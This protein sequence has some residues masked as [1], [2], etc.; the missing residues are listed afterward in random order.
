MSLVT[1]LLLAIGALVL[2]HALRHA[3]DA[4]STS[5]SSCSTTI[6]TTFI[7]GKRDWQRKVYHK[8]T[9]EYMKGFYNSVMKVPGGNVHAVVLHDGLPKELMDTY[10]KD[11]M[12]TFEKIDPSR[13]D[14]LL[15]VNDF[16]FLAF[17]D[18]LKS[19]PEWDV[20]FTTDI[21][22][23]QVKHNPCGFV[24]REPDKL[25]VGVEPHQMGTH[26]WMKT[27]FQKMGGQYLRWFNTMG[28]L[29]HRIWNCGIIGG[30]RMKLLGLINDIVKV[31]MD[32]LLTQR[33]NHAEININMGALNWVLHNK[34]RNSDVV[35]DAPLHSTYKKY[36]GW[37]SD[38][39]FVHKLLQ[40]P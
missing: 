14:P 17:Q 16:R 29:D 23:V 7:T 30:K 24:S 1:R 18:Q 21:S 19:H 31:E 37:R 12:L 40:L 26:P 15:G 10:S 22:D 20:V 25:Y 34:Y 28:D 11:G 5:A 3:Q 13:Y 2:S 33:K 8:P 36:E 39:Y 38:V 9:I 32:P 27:L 4:A 35:S 6:L